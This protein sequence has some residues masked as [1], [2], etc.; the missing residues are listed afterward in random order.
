[1]KN[2]GFTFNHKEDNL[3]EALGLTDGTLD[4]I[5]PKIIGLVQEFEAE[6]LAEGKTEGTISCSKIIEKMI[7]SFTD[8]EIIALAAIQIKESIMDAEKRA[9]QRQQLPDGLMQML[10]SFKPSDKRDLDSQ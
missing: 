10:A 9:I 8:V 1:M 2:P 5:G 3:N 7:D 6:D 4:T